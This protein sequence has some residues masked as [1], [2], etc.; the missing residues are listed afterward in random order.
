MISKFELNGELFNLGDTINENKEINISI[1]ITKSSIEYN[2]KFNINPKVLRIYKN[3]EYMDIEIDYDKEI[4]TSLISEKGY[5]R[6]E[7]LGSIKN[8]KLTKILVSSP[9][10]VR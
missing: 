8:N 9:I 1:T 5:I 3:N 7:V 2:D 4:N 6:F 10:Y